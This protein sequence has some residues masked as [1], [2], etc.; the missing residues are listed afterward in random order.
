MQIYDMNL[1][2]LRYRT[3]VKRRLASVDK[4]TPEFARAA[5]RALSLSP[6]ILALR[7]DSL[8]RCASC[9]NP[10]HLGVE[11]CNGLIICSGCLHEAT[12]TLKEDD[13]V[14]QIP[15]NKQRAT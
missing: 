4:P 8:S 11:L 6:E 1:A 3:A 2:A 13:H 5:T 7:M 14:T 9:K 10:V 15:G 12:Q